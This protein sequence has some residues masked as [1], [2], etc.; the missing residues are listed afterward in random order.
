[1]N[2]PALS[3]ALSNVKTASEVG[4]AVLGKALDQNEIQGAGIV[5]MIASVPTET[6]VNPA[7]G[8]NLDMRV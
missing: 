2:I 4:T 8:S 5:N 6:S 1:M 7:V 3:M